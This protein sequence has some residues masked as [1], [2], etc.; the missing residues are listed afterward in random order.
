[1][2]NTSEELLHLSFCMSR[3]EVD[4]QGANINQLLRIKS[5]VAL[6]VKFFSYHFTIIPRNRHNVFSFNRPIH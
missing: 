4:L 1:M 3:L 5:L 6:W 2:V